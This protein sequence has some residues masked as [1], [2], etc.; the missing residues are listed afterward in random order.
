MLTI[1]EITARVEKGIARIRPFLVED[2]G[3]LEL[4]EITNELVVK[5]RFVGACRDCSMNTMTFVAGVEEA[6]LQAAPEIKRVEALV[7]ENL[8][9]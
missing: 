7:D 9:A 6:I 8:I 2:G 5:V 3:N 1:P 4:V